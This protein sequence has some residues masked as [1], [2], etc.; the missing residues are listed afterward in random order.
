MKLVIFGATGAAGRPLVEQALAAGHEVTA[1]ARIPTRHERLRV[2]R[3]DVADG[4]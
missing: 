1:V 2:M 3:G 4:R